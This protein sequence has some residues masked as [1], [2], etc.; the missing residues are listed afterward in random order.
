MKNYW[1]S[2]GS[3]LSAFVI[4]SWVVSW[5]TTECGSA[6]TWGW[7][8]WEGDLMRSNAVNG[9]FLSKALPSLGSFPLALEG[10]RMLWCCDGWLKYCLIDFKIFQWLLLKISQRIH[11]GQT[12]E[13]SCWNANFLMFHIYQAVLLVLFSLTLVIYCIFIF[14]QSTDPHP[15]QPFYL[16]RQVHLLQVHITDV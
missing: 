14:F 13:I 10:I 4:G 5:A 7:W 12:W 11:S 1:I 3:C 6:W 16:F 15:S 8:H 9:Q 2:G